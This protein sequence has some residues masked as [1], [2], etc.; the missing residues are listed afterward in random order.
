[1][2]AEKKDVF[3]DF[4]DLMANHAYRWKSI[5]DGENLLENLD[6]PVYKNWLDEFFKDLEAHYNAIDDFAN[7]AGLKSRFDDLSC[8]DL[9]K[10]IKDFGTTKFGDLRKGGANLFDLGKKKLDALK[11]KKKKEEKSLEEA[12]KEVAAIQEIMDKGFSFE[13][14]YCIHFVIR[15]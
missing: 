6:N 11:P 5:T 10:E 8:E 9:L 14:A 2:E 15:K 1:M 3:K 12:R 4:F 13:D 7:P